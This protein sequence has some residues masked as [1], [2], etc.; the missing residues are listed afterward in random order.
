MH[1]GD[2][3]AH[4][5]QLREIRADHQ[6]RPGRGAVAPG[7]EPVDQPIDVLLAGDVDPPGGFIE[8]QDVDPLMEQACQGDLLLIASRKGRDRSDAGPRL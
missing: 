5:Q 6:D 7:G 8:E 4:P 2:P 3:V 1:H